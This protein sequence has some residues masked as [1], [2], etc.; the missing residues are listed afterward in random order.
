MQW[1]KDKIAVKQ[2]EG[3]GYSKPYIT[4]EAK[5]EGLREVVGLNKEDYSFI[6]NTIIENCMNE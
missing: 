5:I 2:E 4:Q 6:A 3:Y 1:G